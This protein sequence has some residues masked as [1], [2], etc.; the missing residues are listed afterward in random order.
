M[1]IAAVEPGLPLYII[2]APMIP[3]LDFGGS[4]PELHFANA[5][6]YPAPAYRRLLETL[7]PHYHVQAMVARPLWA[8]SRPEAIRSWRPLVDDLVRYLD[9]REA[10]GWLGVGHS[11]G[12]VVSTAAALRRPELFRALVLI[13]P[14]FLRPAVLAVFGLFQKLG[15]AGRVHPLVPAARRRRRSFDSVEAMFARYRQAR[16]FAGLDDGALRDYAAAALRPAASGDGALALAWTPEWEARVY[17]TGPLNLWGTLHRLQVPVLAI[18]GAQSDTFTP[19]GVRRLRQRLPQVEVV[20]VAGAGHL[21][22]LER[23]EVVGRL[24][25]AFGARVEAGAGDTIPR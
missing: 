24:I 19:A 17:E 11:L 4:G 14:V 12:A 1:L 6:G 5:N 10:R 15:L 20:E 13:D 2:T 21:V 7:T 3:S 22:A 9:E 25:A 18:R 23:P 16:V 8:G